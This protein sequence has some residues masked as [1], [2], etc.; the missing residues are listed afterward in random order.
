MTTLPE[1]YVGQVAL[2]GASPD[3]KTV[4]DCARP[5]RL[6]RAVSI[7]YD[8]PRETSIVKAKWGRARPA[9]PGPLPCRIAGVMRRK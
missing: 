1:A 6:E 3:R 7:G 8:G 5:D 9:G 4:Y 2:S